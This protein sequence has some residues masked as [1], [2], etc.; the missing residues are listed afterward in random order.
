M[1]YVTLKW[2]HIL[3]STLLFGT[4]IGTAFYLYFVSRTRDVRAVAVVSRFVVV[5]DYLFTATTAVFQPL[6]GAWLAHVAGFPM[7]SGWVAWSFVL[8]ALAG[9]CWLPVV[10]IQI[11]LRDLAIEAA[12]RDAPLPARYWEYLRV[13]TILGMPA[14]AAFVVIFWL[15]VAKPA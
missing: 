13:W 7:T 3:S 15:M 11:R 2:L 6:S 14:F 4:G 10:W 9:A 12:R 1:D 8:Y 5:A